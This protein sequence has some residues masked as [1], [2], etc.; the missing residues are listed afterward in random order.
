[1]EMM[2]VE[3]HANVRRWEPAQRR[4]GSLLVLGLAVL[5][6]AGALVAWY[7]FG[8]ASD[9]LYWTL[10][11]L[12]ALVLVFEVLLYALPAGAR[13]ARHAAMGPASREEYAP[14][15]EQGE[16]AP[17]PRA[18]PRTLTLRCGDCGT[19][20]DLTDTGERP[21]YHACPGCGAEGV[22]RDPV[23]APAPAAEP[24]AYAPPAERL[25]AQQ[26]AAPLKRLKLRCGGCK[27]VFAIEDTG[28]RPLK[29][30]CPNCG[31]MGMI[32]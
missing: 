30:A 26:A 20:F 28:E 27:E 19:V 23:P 9:A 17:A 14:P 4:V 18:A 8:V 24:E 1:M 12:V 13:T 16:R 3:M 7:A 22:L 11:A 32:R 10:L 5:V 31:R 29:R 21:L 2:G 15:Q 25:V 6:L